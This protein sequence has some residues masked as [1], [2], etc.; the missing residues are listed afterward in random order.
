MFQQQMQQNLA[1]ADVL[2]QLQQGQQQQQ[3]QQQ[4]PNVPLTASHPE[5]PGQ[6]SVP[7][8]QPENPE[9]TAAMQH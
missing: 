6:T 4:E 2:A 8:N 3:Q 1:I 5:N 9:Q 7:Q